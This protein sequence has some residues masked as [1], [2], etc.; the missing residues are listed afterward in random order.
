MELILGGMASGKSQYA[1]QRLRLLAGGVPL[2]YIGTIQP[3]VDDDELAQKIV[4]H[5]NRRGVQWHTVTATGAKALV[6]AAQLSLSYAVLL[7]GLGLA[8]AAQRE[9]EAWEA[10]L[11]RM[12]QDNTGILIIVSDQVGEGLV[13]AD[14]DTRRFVQQLGRLNQRLAGMAERVELVVAG[15]PLVLKGAASP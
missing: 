3:E 7:D 9:D 1:E 11:H 4:V 10:A 13:P 12:R 14:R 15:I 5:Q 2:A 8:L 6:Q